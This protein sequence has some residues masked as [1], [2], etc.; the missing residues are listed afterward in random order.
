MGIEPMAQ[1]TTNLCSTNWAIV[2]IFVVRV[3]F[4]PTMSNHPQ[5][6]DSRPPLFTLL[7]YQPHFTSLMDWLPYGSGGILLI[8]DSVVWARIELA[9]RGFSVHCSTYWAITPYMSNN[10][11]V[12]GGVSNRPTHLTPPSFVNTKIVN[13]FV[14]HNPFQL[15]FVVPVGFEPTTLCM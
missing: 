6:M 9:A 13:I 7:S 8:Q 3:G 10:V 14:S 4:E 12:S 2:T 11:L 5:R 15:F 1:G